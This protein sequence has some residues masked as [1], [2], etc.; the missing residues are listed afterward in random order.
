V[1]L[2]R[3]ARDFVARDIMTPSDQFTRA[4]SAA[5]AAEV[6]GKDKRFDVIPIPEKGRVVEFWESHTAQSGTIGIQHVVSADTPILDLVDSLRDRRF[7]FVVGQ[8]DVVG[9]VH[10]SDLNDAVVKL[11]FFALL[12]GL[13][14]KAA[15]L[16]RGC[17]RCD[18]LEDFVEN[19]TGRYKREMKKLRGKGANRDWVTLFSFPDVLKAAAK[20]GKLRPELEAS[21]VADLKKVRNSVAHAAGEPLVEAHPED[22]Q[23]L[24]RVRDLCI[25]HL[26]M[27]LG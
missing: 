12:T 7:V 8:H 16:I 23:R 26:G 27:G 2:Q 5:G 18:N 22:V 24:G 21:Q 11:A 6:F 19:S 1:N 10:F 17:V 15:E 14:H 4:A 20:S 25:K 13:E 3:L 9:L